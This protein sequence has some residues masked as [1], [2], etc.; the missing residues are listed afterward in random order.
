MRKRKNTKEILENKVEKE[1]YLFKLQK[2]SQI[3]KEY[4]KLKDKVKYKKGKYNNCLI[5]NNL[6]N[7]NG[8]SNK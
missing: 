7:K 4:E 5:K 1:L 8:V 6:N 3:N 2:F